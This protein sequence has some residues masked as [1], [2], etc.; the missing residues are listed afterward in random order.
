MI[1]VL[2]C[3]YNEERY[4]GKMI[5]NILASKFE[6]FQLLI[7]D[8]GSIDETKTSVYKIISE[9]SHSKIKY[10]YQENGGVYSAINN[11]LTNNL[12]FVIQTRAFDK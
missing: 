1:T 8:D 7:V 2:T 6:K 4:I 5:E 12:H 9:N 10:I 3:T 11:G